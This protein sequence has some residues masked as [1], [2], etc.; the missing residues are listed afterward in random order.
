MHYTVLYCVP[1]PQTLDILMDLL[2]TTR[3]LLGGRVHEGLYW[4]ATN[5]LAKALPSLKA[6]LARHPHYRLLVLGYSLGA[7]LAQLV[8][9][10]CERGACARELAAA[11]ARPVITVLGYGS[12]PVFAPGPRPGEQLPELDSAGYR[13][14]AALVA[15]QGEVPVLDNLLLVQYQDDGISGASL[16]NIHDLLQQTCRVSGLH[17]RRRDLLGLVFNTEEDEDFALLDRVGEE[18][19]ADYEYFP[20][21]VEMI[22]FQSDNS[23]TPQDRAVNNP[24]R[25]LHSAY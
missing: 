1:R 9:L 10:D 4:G 24:S 17:L 13:L 18:E 12:P 2:A 25:S 21:G 15:E 3:P 7:G 14:P 19:E 11:G 22:E 8:A 5:L 20:D 6:A 16:K 23:S